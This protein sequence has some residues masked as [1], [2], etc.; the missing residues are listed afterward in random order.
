MHHVSLKGRVCLAEA[1][2]SQPS[3][4]PDPIGEHTDQKGLAVCP[5]GDKSA[6]P[7]VFTNVVPIKMKVLP[8]LLKPCPAYGIRN[9]E[10]PVITA[11]RKIT[12]LNLF[13]VE[14]L[15]FHHSLA[16][17]I[18]PLSRRAWVAASE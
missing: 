12:R 8:V 17:Y 13:E 16:R 18:A 9:G 5:T 3:E 1:E 14:L 10:R 4:G 2:L 6:Q 15:L 7:I 11:Q